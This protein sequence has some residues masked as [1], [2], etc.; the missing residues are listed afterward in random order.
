VTQKK[1]KLGGVRIHSSCPDKVCSHCSTWQACVPKFKFSPSLAATVTERR[2][3]Q[4]QA[5]EFRHWAL[6]K[7]R[8]QLRVSLPV[9]GPR[10]AGKPEPE[11]L[12]RVTVAGIRF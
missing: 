8:Y 4:A 11:S 1:F 7:S 3:A 9:S 6:L 5:S 12:F 10:A 2:A